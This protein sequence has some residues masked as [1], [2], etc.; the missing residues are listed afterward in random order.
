GKTLIDCY[1][2]CDPTP[3]GYSFTRV[4]GPNQTLVITVAKL[5]DAGE[6]TCWTTGGSDKRCNLIV[7]GPPIITNFLM[8]G[9]NEPNLEVNQGTEVQLECQGLPGNPPKAGRLVNR[10]GVEIHSASSLSSSRFD[11]S[12]TLNGQCDDAGVYS[13]EAG[14]VR[15]DKTLLV[16]CPPIFTDDNPKELPA[17]AFEDISMT[18]SVRT[19]TK[20]IA[21]CRMEPITE[22]QL[23][24][25]SRI[26]I[27]CTRSS[28]LD[29]SPPDL[30]LTVRLPKVTPQ[31]NGNW[32][33]VLF[34]DFG[35]RPFD[36]FLSVT[37]RR[38]SHRTKMS[39]AAVELRDVTRPPD[40]PAPPIPH[41]SSHDD[42]Q[43]YSEIT[44]DAG[45][46]IARAAVGKNPRIAS[47]DY[48]V[49]HPPPDKHPHPRPDPEYVDSASRPQHTTR[50][51]GTE[52]PHED[53]TQLGPRQD[54]GD[55]TQLH[56]GDSSDKGDYTQL[57]PRED[58]MSTREYTA[59]APRKA[60]V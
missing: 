10:H 9:E 32:R 34:N 25:T 49:P 35:S 8:N 16:R 43:I 55:Y 54:R 36:F 59:F 60:T 56:G 21:R 17:A 13:C 22:T 38:R 44:D 3:E 30:T 42:T 58:R 14:D 5:A 46:L 29:G 57:G 6:Y 50:T 52:V 48:L 15:Q 33:L 7:T 4:P 37:E 53:Y 20:D 51:E 40:Q 2:G 39:P 23:E 28:D 19:H 18:F 26:V 12:T 11:V 24:D 45:H 47:D 27:D 41:V 31:M 1:P